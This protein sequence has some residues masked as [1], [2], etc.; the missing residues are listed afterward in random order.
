[1][2]K[3]GHR[4]VMCTGSLKNGHTT[5]TVDFNFGLLVVRNVPAKICKKCGEE[6]IDNPVAK[7]LESL[8]KKVKSKRKEC[9]IIQYKEVI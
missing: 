5:Y 8:V 3:N 1:M 7:K 9:E 6:W 2:K 4:C